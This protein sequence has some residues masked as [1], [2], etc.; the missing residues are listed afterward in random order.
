MISHPQVLP[1]TAL[2]IATIIH[3]KLGPSVRVPLLLSTWRK[4]N[5]FLILIPG[6]FAP[7]L[8][9]LN[10][11]EVVL[12][13][14]V[15]SNRLFRPSKLFFFW[16]GAAWPKLA[17]C[18][19]TKCRDVL[20]RAAREVIETVMPE[21]LLHKID[22]EHL[23]KRLLLFA[24]KLATEQP[25]QVQ[26]LDPRDLVQD[27]LLRYF[28]SP[29]QL[30]WIPARS[31]LF[32]F[33]C[34]VMVNIAREHKR[35]NHRIGASLS[36]PV[37]FASVAENPSLC[38]DPHP[39]LEAKSELELTV[40]I[41]ETDD[42]LKTF[43]EAAASVEGPFRVQQIAQELGVSTAKARALQKRLERKLRGFR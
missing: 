24:I 6:I 4:G 9:H 30:R 27:V 39:A 23:Y 17:F 18:N 1:M 42:E 21:E 3:A 34:G 28:K 35:R 10:S 25:G 2:A 31:S 13:L 41:S 29:S 5:C 11:D 7:G 22:W 32:T 38:V 8:F 37:V 36:D 14:F 16:G 15:E 19:N 26:R 43:V 12:Y 40:D 20:P 33:L